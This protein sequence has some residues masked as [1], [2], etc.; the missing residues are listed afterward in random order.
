MTT[1][2]AFDTMVGALRKNGFN[3]DEIIDLL[4][5]L[6]DLNKCATF[7][8][9]MMGKS[10]KEKLKELL[11]QLAIPRNVDGYKYIQSAIILSDE[12][13]EWAL[14]NQVYP[15]VAEMFG[16]TSSK[17]ERRIRY[18]I[19]MRWENIDKDDIFYYFGNTISEKRR[20]P[21]NSEFIAMCVEW[22]NR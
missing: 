22:I 15:K 14:T 19:Q 16:T 10:K 2:E 4:S 21:T 3:S 13:P 5:S 18:A 7:G 8:S 12:N 1:K 6:L 17:V 11:L 9:L 20:Y